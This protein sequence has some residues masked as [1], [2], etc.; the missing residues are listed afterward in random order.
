MI[1]EKVR[2]AM[3][4]AGVKEG[5]T[6]DLDVVESAVGEHVTSML[7]I[8]S[9]GIIDCVEE[10]LESIQDTFVNLRGVLTEMYPKRTFIHSQFGLEDESAT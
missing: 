4:G 3:T 10:D 8:M 2:P 7:K 1:L 9:E 6:V 5:E